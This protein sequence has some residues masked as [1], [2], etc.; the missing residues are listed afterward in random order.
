M[1]KNIICCIHIHLRS[2]ALMARTGQKNSRVA[3]KSSTRVFCRVPVQGLCHPRRTYNAS[4]VWLNWVRVALC[5]F[6]FN[7]ASTQHRISRGRRGH[8]GVWRGSPPGVRRGPPKPCTGTRQ[9][10]RVELLSATREFFCK[11]VS[12]H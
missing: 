4:R 3:L 10:T 1:W 7:L 12:G 8:I 2:Q 9:N 11:S 6:D 5:M